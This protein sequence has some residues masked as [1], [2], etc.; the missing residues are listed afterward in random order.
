MDCPL[1]SVP[2]QQTDCHGVQV[3]ECPKCRGDWFDRD[4]LRRAKDSTDA[5]LRWLDFDVFAGAPDEAAA[6][7][8]SR[9]CPRCGVAMGAVAYEESGV[10][11]DKCGSCHGVWLDHDEFK[12]IVEHLEH[13]VNAETAAQLR[14]EAAH[15]LAEVFTGP[16]GPVAEVR[17]LLT[18]LR[19]L[20]LRVAVEH[21]GISEALDEIYSVNPFK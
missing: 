16:E 11:V 4:E 12:K 18:V 13:R 19:L 20:R 7:G 3:D 17:D 6:R 10:T 2:L 15:E 1:C 14:G 5:D 21:P 8:R 9:L